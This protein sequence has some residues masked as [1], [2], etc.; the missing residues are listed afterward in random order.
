MLS[1]SDIRGL[2]A[3]IPTPAKLGAEKIDATD[4]V[5]LVETER[6]VNQLLEDGVNGLIVLGT[7]GECATLTNAEYDGFVECVLGTVNRRVPTFV[8]TTALGSHEIYRRMKL[9]E[10][11]GAEGTL[12]GLPMWQPLATESA[13]KFYREMSEHFPETAIM[14][15]ANSRAFRF[16]F[17]ADFWSAVVKEAPTV[18]SAKYSRP[19]HYAEY[20]KAS[21]GRINF[22]PN[23]MNVSKF[24]EISPDTTT[25]S[26]ATAAA[27]GPAPALAIVEAIAKRNQEAIETLTAAIAWATQPLKV[28]THDPEVFA[29]YNIQAEKVRINEAGY[30]KAG[31]HRPPY[32]YMPAEFEECAREN[33]RR[34]A[35]LCEAYE[36]RFQFKRRVW[37]E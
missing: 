26:W 14:V 1:A 33:G 18:T 8:G 3:I 9:I 20:L 10:R 28:L 37:E 21:E 22:V 17:P 4:T 12:L 29:S 34:W 16:S 31:P 35:A 2:Y 7:T 19:Q 13:V 32:D 25:A 27:M 15:Y 11:L 6:V 23:E 24:Y 36:G 5:D 30:C